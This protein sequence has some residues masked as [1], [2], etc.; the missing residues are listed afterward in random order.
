MI[1]LLGQGGYGSVYL[2]RDE[3]LARDVA[4]KVPHTSR[5]LE[6]ESLDEYLREAK[7]VARL[8]L[9]NIVPVYDVGRTENGLCFIVSKFVKGSDLKAKFLDRRPT[10]S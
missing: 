1:R 9:P 7:I 2:A 6:A 10:L 3:R 8:E 5:T 4:V